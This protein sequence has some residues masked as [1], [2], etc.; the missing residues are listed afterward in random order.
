LAGSV[1]IK[2][3][4]DR[5]DRALIAFLLLSGMRDKAVSTLP[6]GCFDRGTL[7]VSQDTSKGVE[8]K[9]GKS[10]I[11]HLFPF[12]EGLLQYVTDWAEYLEKVKLFSSAAPLFPRS[13][14]EQIEGGLTF[15]CREVEPFSWKGTNSIR[16]I[17]KDRASAAR[18]E[19][20]HPHSFRHLA[21][22][23]ATRNCRTAE[24][25]KAV[26]Q[27][28][29]HEYVGTTMVTYGRL[30]EFRVGEIIR[31]MDFSGKNDDSD[32]AGKLEQIR[33]LLND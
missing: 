10:L 22:N 25:V 21:V 5:R 17:L 28:F 13:K 1:E 30:N 32:K 16:E 6:L 7:T 18:L 4:I 8:T 12:D 2:T 3:E 23:L 24:Q 15:I 33:K 31:D 11:T 14:R 19:Y 9:F 26:S 29:G 27:N 20:F